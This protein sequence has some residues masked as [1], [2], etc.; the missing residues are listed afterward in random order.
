MIKSDKSNNEASAVVP[1]TVDTLSSTDELQIFC[2][3]ICLNIFYRPMCLPCG[4]TYCHSCLEQCNSQSCPL[5]RQPFSASIMKSTENYVISEFL[6]KKY[7]AYYKEK[8]DIEGGL[9][10]SS[11]AS[12][13][14]ELPIFVFPAYLFPG[15]PIE[16]N[17]F[18]EKYLVLLERSLAGDKK[19]IIHSSGLKDTIG[20]VVKIEIHTPIRP[21]LVYVS[22]VCTN[23][24]MLIENMYPK[25]NIDSEVKRSIL[26]YFAIQQLF[27]AFIYMLPAKF[28][29]WQSDYH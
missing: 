24:C 7:P 18:E 11:S 23:R 14:I 13:T 3:P 1:S 12:G 9:S 20:N 5:C 8:D 19:F 25:Y 26:L 17:I 21:N 6:R 4:H 29:D 27:N 2:C 28:N 22:L 10:T 16:L 15:Q